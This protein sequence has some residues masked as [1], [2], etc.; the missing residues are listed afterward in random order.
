LSRLLKLN[1]KDPC[2]QLSSSLSAA[3]KGKGLAIEA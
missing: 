1:T 3:K 2:A